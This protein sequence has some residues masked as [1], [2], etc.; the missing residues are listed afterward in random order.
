MRVVLLMTGC[1]VPNC[2]DCL[3]VR[4]VE[5]RRQMY[6]DSIRWYFENTPYEIVFCENSGTDLSDFLPSDERLEILTFTDVRKPGEDQSKSSKE[7]GIL[8]YAYKHS[9]KICPGSLFVK[10][11][12]RL[13][14]LNIVETVNRLEIPSN[15]FSEFISCDLGKTHMW[16]D[17]RLF[18]F[19]YPFFRR[20]FAKR[21]LVNIRYE[22]E[23]LLGTCVYQMRKKKEG[24]FSFLPLPQRISGIGGGVGVEYDI[25]EEEYK[26]KLR[27]HKIF[28]L[29]FD[30]GILPYLKKEHVLK[31]GSK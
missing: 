19:T 5:I 17:S 9:R 26:K 2:N 23:R 24:S 16:S 1:V 14:Y 6:L 18:F 21:T 29:L 15:G 3:S 25:T 11:T 12:G 10:V 30:L 31:Y 8:E 27:R 4:D 13:K 20:M 7:I 28:K 22:F